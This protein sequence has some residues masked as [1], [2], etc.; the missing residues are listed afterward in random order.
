MSGDGKPEATSAQKT[1]FT[2]AAKAI[3]EQS[4]IPSMAANVRAQI[5]ALTQALDTLQPW[6]ATWLWDSFNDSQTVRS[7]L[8]QAL[9]NVKMAEGGT[10]GDWTPETKAMQKVSVT[11][12]FASNVASKSFVDD[13]KRTASDLTATSRS[14]GGAVLLLGAGYLVW[15]SGA[16]GAGRRSNPPHGRRTR[17]RRGR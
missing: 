7:N 6:K 5:S 3:F 10:G 13:V 1:Q 4:K 2:N 17:A 16:L 12:T 9:K 11:G 15:K 14:L 8:G